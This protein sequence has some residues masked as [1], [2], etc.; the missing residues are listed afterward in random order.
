MTPFFFIFF[1]TYNAFVCLE[2]L[3]K[4]AGRER[5]RQLQPLGRG[6]GCVA[7]LF[8]STSSIGNGWKG[9]PLAGTCSMLPY[10]GAYIFL[11][12]NRYPGPLH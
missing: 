8:A 3:L 9:T 7:R 4:L 11:G 12:E 10:G 5:L 6:I 1:T 2:G